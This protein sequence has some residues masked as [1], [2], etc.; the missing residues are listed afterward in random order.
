MNI[1]N[2]SAHWILYLGICVHNGLEFVTQ[3]KQESDY[4]KNNPESGTSPTNAR[5]V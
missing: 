1:S 3:T 5:D 2:T 4:T